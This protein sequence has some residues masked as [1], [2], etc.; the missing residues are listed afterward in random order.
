VRFFENKN[1]VFYSEKNA[2][3]YYNSGV[4]VVN[5][6]VVGLVLAVQSPTGISANDS[7]LREVSFT[8]L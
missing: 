4:A 1:S 6:K 2:T 5:S 7:S 3:A 8:D